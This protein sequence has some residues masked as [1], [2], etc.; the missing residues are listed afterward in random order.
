MQEHESVTKC[1]VRSYVDLT[2]SYFNPDSVLN[3][4]EKMRSLLFD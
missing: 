3:D 1:N 2:S 4:T